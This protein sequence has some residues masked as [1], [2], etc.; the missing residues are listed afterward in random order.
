MKKKYN[1]AARTSLISFLSKHPDRQF[2]IEELCQKVNGDVKTGK[3][4]IYRQMTSLCQDA[5]V[6][7]FQNEEKKCSVY[8]YI[9]SGCDCDRHFHQQCIDCG[10]ITHLDCHETAH[11][12][13]HL[14][15]EHGFLVMCGRSV[16]YGLCEQCRKQREE[17][18]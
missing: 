18:K 16:L 7:K 10:S 1:T 15:Q 11:F 3:S 4:S 9:G 5:V 12:A 8:Q 6:R 17:I 13:Q 14:L 2:T